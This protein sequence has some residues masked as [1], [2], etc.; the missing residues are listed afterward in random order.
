M[1]LVMRAPFLPIGSL[2]IWTRI[3]CPSFS[4]S[5]IRGSA[6]DCV[7]VAS[8]HPH[9]LE[10]RHGVRDVRDVRNAPAAG[11]LLQERLQPRGFQ[12]RPARRLPPLL[13]RFVG[14]Q[15]GF[16][17][18]LAAEVVLCIFQH[19][20][21]AILA[22]CRPELRSVAVLEGVL[23]DFALFIAI[24]VLGESGHF[25]LFLIE[26][27][28]LDVAAFN[29]KAAK[30]TGCNRRLLCPSLCLRRTFDFGLSL[31]GGKFG[32]IRVCRGLLL[33]VGDDSFFVAS[34]E[35]LRNAIAP[36]M[37]DRAALRLL[38]PHVPRPTPLPHEPAH[39]TR[40]RMARFPWVLT[41][42]ALVRPALSRAVP[43][44]REARE[45]PLARWSTPSARRLRIPP[46][47]SRR[48]FRR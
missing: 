15:L 3:S 41:R 5:L 21:F 47:L 46:V 10:V 13:P 14:E 12:P 23:F 45:P 8:V 31:S 2:A 44:Q 20:L 32:L 27:F 38:R 26:F 29:H 6:R 11:V 35:D 22:N 4:N 24:E 9:G 1:W 28:M 33:R 37:T 30:L 48:R 16:L 17:K 19:I 39:R 18:L 43:R 36:G 42:F 34:A 25:C 7:A 40:L